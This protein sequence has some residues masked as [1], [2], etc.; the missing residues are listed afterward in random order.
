M[1]RNVFGL[2][3]HNSHDNSA[4]TL[5][6]TDFFKEEI[7]MWLKPSSKHS[8]AGC[9]EDKLQFLEAEHL[10]VVRSFLK[11]EIGVIGELWRKSN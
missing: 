10:W 3:Q 4:L 11:R 8:K 7:T 9:A 6:T 1:L 5:Y 2:R